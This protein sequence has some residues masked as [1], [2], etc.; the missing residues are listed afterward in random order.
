MLMGGGVSKQSDGIECDEETPESELNNLEN[1]RNSRRAEREA[2]SRAI[3]YSEAFESQSF[4]ARYNINHGEDFC[5]QSS[6]ALFKLDEEIRYLES[7]INDLKSV[8]S[9]RTFG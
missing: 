2:L 6:S 8:I 3:N 5:A 4:F 7:R 1:D 9:R